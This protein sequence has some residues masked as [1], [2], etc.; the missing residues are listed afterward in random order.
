MFGL[1]VL[2]ALISSG[3]GSVL[4]HQDGAHAKLVSV[5]R[6]LELL[7]PP[8]GAAWPH[9]PTILLL[10]ERWLYGCW[11][12]HAPFPCT[13][14]SCVDMLTILLNGR[15]SFCCKLLIIFFLF[16]LFLLLSLFFSSPF[17][18]SLL[19][20]QPFISHLRSNSLGKQCLQTP[21]TS[22]HGN[23]KSYIF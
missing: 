18:P 5:V 14:D 20:P 9:V 21:P 19:T 11:A 22:P 6:S 7:T 10:L 23:G 13:A 16:I 12:S 8:R 17:F 15:Y 3:L 4:E 1:K 2:Q